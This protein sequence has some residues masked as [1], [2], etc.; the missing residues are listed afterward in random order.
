VTEGAAAAGHGGGGVPHLANWLS[1]LAHG[2]GIETPLGR[3]IHQYEDLLFAGIIV[4]FLSGISWVATRNFQRIPRGLQNLLEVLVGGLNS[5]FE[6]VMGPHAKQF[7]PFVGALFLYIWMMNWAGLIPGMKSPTAS[8]NTTLGL[9]LCVFVYL[10]WTGLRANGIKGYFAHLMESPK[11]AMTFVIG[12]LFILPI[13][14]VGELVKPISLA[15]RLAFNI[16]G[17]D[18]FLA[19]AVT[20]GP[21]G[22]LLQLMAMG[23]SLILGTV[24]ALVFSTL[25][26]VFLSL[27]LP[28]HEEHEVIHSQTVSHNEKGNP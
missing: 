2:V 5:F 11:D 20:L 18:T 25:S 7:A 21:G 9:A 23:L 28:H 4:A 15:M 6:G 27:M 13:H 26:A 1:W 3:F 14:L 8:I 24:Q 22:I 16:T 17:E 10:Q 12:L 19:V